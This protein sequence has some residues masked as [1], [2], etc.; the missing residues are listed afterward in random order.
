MKSDR[1]KEV[2]MRKVKSSP[3]SVVASHESACT[4]RLDGEE[5]RFTYLFHEEDLTPDRWKTLVVTL[6]PAG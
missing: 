6:H 4:A 5:A 1:E 3:P 2:G